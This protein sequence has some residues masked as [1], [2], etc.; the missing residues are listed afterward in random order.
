MMLRTL[1]AALLLCAGLAMP[2]RA[3]DLQLQVVDKDCWV[4]IFDDEKYDNNKPHV[5][6]MG[7]NEFAT[8]KDLSGK[9]WNNEIES[10]VVGP[11]ATV[12]AYKDRD[13]KGTEVAFT[14]GQR[15][16]D[17]GK[18]KMGNDIESMKIECGK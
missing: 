17:L 15:V 7:P 12:R 18:L 4:E 1:C 10:L 8:L 13:F 9:N 3:A 6:I 2:A 14:P 11:N 5:K 16:P